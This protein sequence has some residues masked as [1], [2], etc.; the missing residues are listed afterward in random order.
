MLQWQVKAVL[1]TDYP[2]DGPL[3]PKLCEIKAV[4]M[5]TKT[6]MFGQLQV[7][8]ETT[9]LVC[10]THRLVT[11][12]PCTARTHNSM[13]A[14]YTR[15]THKAEYV[16]TPMKTPP[17]RKSYKPGRLAMLQPSCCHP[18]PPLSL[19]ALCM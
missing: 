17:F 6:I 15:Y 14:G 19:A 13:Y 11:V 1:S 3:P 8:Q 12:S 5:Q 18:L 10:G 4:Y 2:V 9:G 16:G 7:N